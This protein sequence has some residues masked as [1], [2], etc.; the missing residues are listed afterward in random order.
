MSEFLIF[1]GAFAAALLL[2]FGLK[3]SAKKFGTTNLEPA[4]TAFA[5]L[6]GF[7]PG[8]I[9]VYLGSAIAHDAASGRIAVW[10]KASGA[11][12]LQRQ[13]VGAWHSGTLL[14]V[15]LN[16][17]TA[18]PMVQLYAQAH[19]DKP[20][21]KVGVLDKNDCNRWEAYLGKAFGANKSREIAIR[22]LGAN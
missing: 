20:F 21:F 11:R 3:W 15:V 17:T 14:T 13:D 10:E 16:R 1:T 18:T 22:V 6:P 19:D 2:F 8:D 7:A 12:L 5:A 9:L 4:R